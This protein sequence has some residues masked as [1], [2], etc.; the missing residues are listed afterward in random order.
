[1]GKWARQT[2]DVE[3]MKSF[4]S[5][6]FDKRGDST[7][8]DVTYV[9][10]DDYIYT[11]EFKDASPFGGVIRWVPSNHSDSWI[12]SR[13]ISRWGGGAV[14]LKL[15]EDC[16]QVL[17]VDVGYTSNDERV[18]N[19]YYRSTEGKIFAK[20]YREGL[21]NRHLSGWLEVRAK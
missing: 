3:G 18:K 14:N 1:M 6:S 11:R 8:K 20:E 4:I 13:A 9:A 7:V 2:L 10:A 17:G 5:I 12:Q 21:V 15:P 19:L 16:A